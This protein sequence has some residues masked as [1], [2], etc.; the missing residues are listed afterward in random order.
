MDEVIRVIENNERWGIPVISRITGFRHPSRFV[1][2]PDG[3]ATAAIIGVQSIQT[4][5]EIYDV[6]LWHRRITRILWGFDEDGKLIEVYVGST[7]SP[8]LR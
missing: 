5:P 4:R 7:F 6:P 1:D 8:Q 2:G 3:S